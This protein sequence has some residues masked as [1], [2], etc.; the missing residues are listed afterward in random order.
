M[1][2]KVYLQIFLFPDK[3]YFSTPVSMMEGLE[4]NGSLSTFQAQSY[5]EKTSFSVN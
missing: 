5:M 2:T 4:I 3:L 1:K